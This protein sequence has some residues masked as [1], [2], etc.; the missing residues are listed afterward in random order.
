MSLLTQA[1]VGLIVTVLPAA[2]ADTQTLT[3]VVSPELFNS[4]SAFEELKRE[5]AR[6]VSPADYTFAWLQKGRQVLGEAF[7]QVVVIQ[8]RGACHSRPEGEISIA[9]GIRSLAT[10]AVSD[11]QVLPFVQVDCDRTRQLVSSVLAGLP[12]GAREA[13]YGRALGRVLAHELYHVL[14]Q[15]TSHKEQGVSKPCF[16]LADL[17]STRFRFD[18]VSIAQMRP[19]AQ[20]V[21]QARPADADAAADDVAGR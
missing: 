16:R 1:L 7:E 18:A 19:A 15:T 4:G 5:T 10:T 13:L 21:A 3:L 8:F 14:A 20:T 17:L 6:L 11:G 12:S 9:G 2:A